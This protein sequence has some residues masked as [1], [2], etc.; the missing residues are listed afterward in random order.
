M[1][2][3]GKHEN[4][5]EFEVAKGFFSVNENLSTGKSAKNFVQKIIKKNKKKQNMK[6]SYKLVTLGTSNT[7]LQGKQHRGTLPAQIMYI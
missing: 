3:Y 1:D 2:N 5:D 4:C 7:Q 6:N